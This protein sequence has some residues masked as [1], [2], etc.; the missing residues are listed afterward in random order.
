ML[1]EAVSRVY[2]TV[3]VNTAECGLV[4]SVSLAAQAPCVVV[5]RTCLVSLDRWT[6]DA[7]L[8]VPGTGWTSP[9]A[10]ETPCPVWLLPLAR[11]AGGG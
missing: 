6:G 5:V 9:S 8:S 2:T 3:S 4:H 10:T 1:C 7:L 11:A